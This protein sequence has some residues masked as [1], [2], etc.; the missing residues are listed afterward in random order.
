MPR[1]TARTLALA[2]AVA[3][4]APL[5]AQTP[6]ADVPETHTVKQGDTLWDLSRQYF[7]DPVLWPRIYQMNTAV[8]EDPHWIFPGEVLRLGSDGA[9]SSVPASDFP[10]ATDQ[11]QADPAPG[12]TGSRESAQIVDATPSDQQSVAD[13]TP[14]FPRQGM[15][16]SAPP[17]FRSDFVDSYRAVTRADFNQAGFL[18]EGKS[19]PLGQVLGTVAPSQVDARGS[20]AAMLYSRVAIRPPAPGAYQV[21]D[22]LLAVMVDRNAAP[23][24]GQIVVPT[25]LIRVLDATRPEVLGEVIAQYAA[26]TPDCQVLPAEKF[27]D[28]RGVRPQPFADGAEGTLIAFRAT[29]V[30]R[31]VGDIVFVDK[32]RTEGM[33]LGDVLEARRTKDPRQP[34]GSALVPDVVARLQ[35][36]HLGDQTATARVMWVSY[37]DIPTGTRWKLV[38]R[39]P[40]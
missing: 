33:Q 15:T 24:V 4:P 14:I 21:G 20:Q 36:V 34:T 35:I 22:T 39:L 23:G 29:D 13:T 18:T 26:I 28:R 7:G 1:V 30:L 19:L 10:S 2:L 17:V 37:P 40:G 8:V 16:M 27:T 6:A 5:L 3:M 32:G 9:V 31:G 11:V 38:A 25:G 12:D